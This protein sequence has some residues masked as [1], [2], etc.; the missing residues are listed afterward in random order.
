MRR[1]ATRRTQHRRAPSP[2][3]PQPLSPSRLRSRGFGIRAAAYRS[4]G[5]V[6]LGVLGTFFGARARTFD[7]TSGALRHRGAVSSIWS[8]TLALVVAVAPGQSEI[9][10]LLAPLRK[11]AAAVHG[12]GGD[13][14]GGLGRVDA[15]QEFLEVLDELERALGAA[16]DGVGEEVDVFEPNDPLAAKHRNGLHAFAETI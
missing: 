14:D 9:G 7:G 5:G 2:L 16:G 6:C 10:V 12:R 1:W 15:G 4:G 8:R 13:E 11:R 3:P